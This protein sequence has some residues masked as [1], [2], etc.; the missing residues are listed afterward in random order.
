MCNRLYLWAGIIISGLL[1]WGCSEDKTTEPIPDTTPPE[2]TTTFPAAGDTGVGVDIHLQVGFSEAMSTS[3]LASQT[4][5]INNLGGS[6]VLASS[7]SATLIPAQNL[8]YNHEY[9]AT[10]TTNVRDAAGN[11]LA[12][13]YVWH[14]TTVADTTRPIVF[15]TDPADGAV[16][17]P[18]YFMDIRALMSKPIDPASVTPS[19]FYLSDGIFGA[20]ETHWDTLIF[21]PEDTL[22]SNQTYTA[23]LTT[24]ITDTLGNAL[25]ADYSWSF[26]TAP[27]LNPPTVGTIDPP[28]GAVD[29]ATHATIRAVMSEPIDPATVTT[30]TFYFIDAVPGMVETHGDTLLLIP[31]SPL[32]NNHTFTV[33]LTTGITDTAGNALAADYSWSFTTVAAPVIMPLATGNS[34]EYYYTTIDTLGHTT[35]GYSTITLMSTT[36]IGNETWFVDNT[37]RKYVNRDDGLWEIKTDSL[38]RAAASPGRLGDSA[39]YVV[40]FQRAHMALVAKDTVITVPAGD[41]VCDKYEGFLYDAIMPRWYRSYYAEGIGMVQ[42]EYAAAY[43]MDG[44]TEKL[45][46]YSFVQ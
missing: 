36:T 44:K 10:V 43:V 29:V 38:Y 27:D 23:T 9:T 4:I 33:T 20:A 26:T 32:D 25:A 42:F 46:S 11:R 45:S 30:S 19:T 7:R 41:F 18:R 1:I 3:T 31:S 24:G 17:V 39:S 16:D 28:A 8:E 35:S 2:V 34:W 14:F 22:L 21:I 37:N 6:T 5:Y 13:D 12:Q 40:Q 15:L